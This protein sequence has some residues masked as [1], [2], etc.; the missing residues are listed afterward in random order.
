[1]MVLKGILLGVGFSVAAMILAWTVLAI[2][3]HSTSFMIGIE[4]FRKTAVLGSGFAIGI[5]A[6]SAG[7]LWWTNAMQGRLQQILGQ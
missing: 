7:L 6:V 4:I 1:M 5:F 2:K 3:V